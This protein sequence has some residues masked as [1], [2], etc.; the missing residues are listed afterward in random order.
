MTKM[1]YELEVS[2]E[3]EKILKKACKDVSKLKERFLSKSALLIYR[4]FNSQSKDRI[5]IFLNRTGHP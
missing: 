5:Q 3:S 4:P 2:V 1:L